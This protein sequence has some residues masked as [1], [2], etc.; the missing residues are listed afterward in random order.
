MDLM[1]WSSSFSTSLPTPSLKS[2]AMHMG[3]PAGIQIPSAAAPTTTCSSQLKERG[4]IFQV[5]L[6]ADTRLLL[7]TSWA[8]NP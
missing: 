2:K 5:L 4:R 7:H 1:T 6:D 8:P 3:G